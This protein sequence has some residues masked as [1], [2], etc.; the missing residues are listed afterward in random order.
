MNNLLEH[1]LLENIGRERAKC[2]ARDILDKLRGGFLS[3]EITSLPDLDECAALVHA[4]INNDVPNLRGLINATGVVLHTNLGRA[5]LGLDVYAAA[6]DVFS[7]YSNLEY[8][9]ETGRRGS[10]YAHVEKLICGLTGAE[11]A[12][13]V[14][15][16]AAA[17]LLAL[18]TLSAGGEVVLSRGE[19]VEI[20]DSFRIADMVAAAG[21]AVREVGATNRTSLADYENAIKPQTRALLK[22]HRSNFTLRGFTGEVLLPEL[23]ALGKKHGLPVVE[24]LGSG[25]LVP[26]KKERTVG[27][28]LREGADIVTFSGDKLL[29]GPQAGLVAGKREYIS[30]MR[31]NPLYRC[32][33]MDKLNLAALCATLGQ[34]MEG[35]EGDIPAVAMLI[36]DAKAVRA[37]AERLRA[38]VPSLVARV[39]T[40]DAAPGGGAMP[41]ETTESFA[42]YV[43]ARS[44]NGLLA[45]LRGMSVPIIGLARRD[46]AVFDLRTVDGS[47]LPYVAECLN[48]AVDF[49]RRIEP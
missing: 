26:Y 4:R 41:G 15:N 32:L 27:D 47:D 36:A 46:E 48:G 19:M 37:K 18:N 12:M 11:A 43:A 17:V 13:V 45:Y 44:V 39:D 14:N 28:A 5:P 6:V 38:L 8:E 22:V 3:G 40:H 31:R 35:E 21:C 10:R 20:G 1:K 30:Q 42:L 25:L 23:A 24:D 34:Y 16:N 9:I 7:G 29:G 33:R 49:I 2:A